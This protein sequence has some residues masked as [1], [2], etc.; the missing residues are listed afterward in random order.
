MRKT[1]IYRNAFRT[2]LLISLVINI[3]AVDRLEYVWQVILYIILAIGVVGSLLFEILNFLKK[4]R[5]NE[6]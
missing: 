4:K 2:I 6:N 3:F 1:I 5:T